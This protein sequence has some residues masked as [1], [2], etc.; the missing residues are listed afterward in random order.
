[1]LIYERPAPKMERATDHWSVA[2][3]IFGAGHYWSLV[4]SGNTWQVFPDDT[5]D[6]NSDKKQKG[7]RKPSDM[8]R[9]L[10]T[11]PTDKSNFEDSSKVLRENPSDCGRGVINIIKAFQCQPRFSGLYND[12][13]ENIAQI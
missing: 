10:V 1:M 13:L 9:P 6:P 2:R 7:T 8:E 5:S 12:G 3:S 11:Q 4:S